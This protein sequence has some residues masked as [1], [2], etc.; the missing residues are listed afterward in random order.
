MLYESKREE[1]K[2]ILI[3]QKNG[4]CYKIFATNLRGLP[5]RVLMRYDQALALSDKR[6]TFLSNNPIDISI[7]DNIVIENGSVSILGLCFEEKEKQ[8]RQIEMGCYSVDLDDIDSSISLTTGKVVINEIESIIADSGYFIGLL[9]AG[10][11]SIDNEAMKLYELTP[12][13]ILYRNNIKNPKKY[14]K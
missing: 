3:K 10:V 2:A 6:G 13:F 5:I 4:I 7:C 8:K 11:V 14:I 1:D 9:N 12:R